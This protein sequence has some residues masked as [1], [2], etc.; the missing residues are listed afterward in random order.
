MKKLLL[1]ASALVI[2]VN[3]NAQIFSETFDTEIPA[4]WTI[5]DQDNLTSTSSQSDYA[6]WAWNSG[7]QSASSSSWY[8]NNGL[9]PTDDWLITPGIAIPATGNF[10]L[11]FNASSHE[12]NYLEEYEVL[13]STTGT[14]VTDFTSPPI[15]SVTNESETGTD[16][17]ITLPASTA[18]QTVYI[19][20]HHI[21]DDES[22]LHL[23]DVVVREL[24]DDDVAMTALDIPT[25]VQS[26]NVTIAGTLS[27]EGANAITSV[28]VTWDDGSGPNTETFAV[29]I[30]PGETYDFTHGTLLAATVAGSPY[31][32]NVCATVTGDGD[33]SNNCA[34]HTL[35]AYDQVGT[36]LALLELFTSSTCPPCQ[37]LN[38]QWYDGSGLN[39]GL[40]ALNAN[41]QTGAN[42][43]AIKY[44]V[45]WPGNGDHAYNTEVGERVQKYS[46]NS[47][48]TPIVNGTAYDGNLNSAAVTPHQTEL[49]LIDLSA[50]FT[51]TETDINVDVTINPYAD[52]SGAKLYVALLDKEYASTSDASFSNGETVFHHVFRKFVANGT[53][54]NLTSGTAFTSMES[55]SFNIA[56][57]LPSQGSFDLHAGS[58]R[59][60]VVFVEDADGNILNAAI[61]TG[62]FTASVEESTIENVNVYP[63]PA[64]DVLNVSFE[65]NNADYTVSLT[66][67]AGRTLTSNTLT[68]LSGAQSI[69]LPVADLANG[70]YILTI[71]SEE[72]S[73]TQKVVIK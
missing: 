72:G 1:G 27:N 25:D 38:E 53:A 42:I 57:D 71:S 60:V 16:H 26:G 63:N 24:L 52:Y 45:N 12:A 32:I 10:Q 13:Y 6:S 15:L 50:T 35:N 8:N 41:A 67:L 14:A 2:S 68:S 54:I 65:A 33:A 56:T 51:N 29:N 59:E 58:Q 64:T 70:N 20:F 49:T 40:D 22:M 62:T 39:A 17:Q 34:N 5:H 28:D 23:D 66:D 73:Y 11:S 21:S 44:Q 48:P 30:A 19:A 55:T 43:A 9:G 18:G 46:V 61:A 3:V 47:A 31:T 69:A 7:R 37:G 36:R 4:T